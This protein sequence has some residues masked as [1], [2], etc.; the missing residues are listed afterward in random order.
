MKIIRVKLPK[1]YLDDINLLIGDNDFIET[2]RKQGSDL[3]YIIKKDI[4]LGED[5]R[6]GLFEKDCNYKLHNLCVFCGKFIFFSRKPYT[7]RNNKITELR[8]CCSCLKIFEGK[9]F[10]ELPI[11]KQKEIEEIITKYLEFNRKEI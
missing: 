9:S 8:A 7:H 2:R 10:E 6:P 3:R 5:L 4:R 1:G 11:S